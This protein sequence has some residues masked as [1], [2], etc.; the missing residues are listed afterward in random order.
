ML[1]QKTLISLLLIFILLPACT[2]PQERQARQVEED[3]Y[4]TALQRMVQSYVYSMSCEALLPL[5]KDLLWESPYDGAAYTEDRTGLTT[6]WRDHDETR[7][8]R[9]TVHSHRAGHDRCAVQF[10]TQERIGHNEHQRRD[11]NREL[12]LLERVDDEEA[13]RVRLGARREAREAYDLTLQRLEQEED[14]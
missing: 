1:G 9:L 4:R 12:E 7:R 6:D 11:V 5:A 10:I 8:S 3:T 14:R 13:N 2:T